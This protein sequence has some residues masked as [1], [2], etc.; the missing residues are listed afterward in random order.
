MLGTERRRSTVVITSA[1]EWA[2]AVDEEMRRF[3]VTD[4]RVCSSEVVTW[5]FT[6]GSAAGV[7]IAREANDNG[8]RRLTSADGR[9]VVRY[10]ELNDWWVPE[11]S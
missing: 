9:W 3:R 2:A 6:I 1:V 7:E 10:D 8:G 5:A 11:V 4:Y